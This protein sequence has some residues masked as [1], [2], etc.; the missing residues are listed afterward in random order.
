MR[1]FGALGL[2]LAL[3]TGC[4]ALDSVSKTYGEVKTSKRRMAGMQATAMLRELL[5][6]REERGKLS[7]EEIRDLAGR[8]ATLSALSGGRS[9]PRTP[10]RGRSG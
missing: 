2:A 5:A 6:V 3:G 7:E 1:G 4:G 8:R 9:S 10:P